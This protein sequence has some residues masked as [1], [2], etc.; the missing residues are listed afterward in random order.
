MCIKY[1]SRIRSSNHFIWYCT[2]LVI[3]DPESSNEYRVSS[4]EYQYETKNRRD[5]ILNGH[6]G[7][8]FVAIDELVNNLT[9]ISRKLKSNTTGFEDNPIRGRVKLVHKGA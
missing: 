4:I 9:R 7:F 6:T 5:L 8:L 3:E 2:K 1:G